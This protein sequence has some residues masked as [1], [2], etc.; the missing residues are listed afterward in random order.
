MYQVIQKA[1]N[2]HTKNLTIMTTENFKTIAA[3]KLNTLSTND[4][5]IEVKKLKDNF[6]KSA[7]YVFDICIDILM[8]RMPENDFV[9]LCDSL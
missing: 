4:L 2:N 1:I 3:Q 9:E 7:E 6:E 8:D 5:I